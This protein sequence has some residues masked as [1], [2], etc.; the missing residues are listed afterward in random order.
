[1]EELAK[2]QERILKSVGPAEAAVKPREILLLL[3][4]LSYGIGMRLEILFIL[5]YRFEALT[6]IQGTSCGNRS[7]II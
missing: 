7:K 1:M 3:K 6:A 5:L 2:S 4:T